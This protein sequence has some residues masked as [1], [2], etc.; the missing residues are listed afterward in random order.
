MKP[1]KFERNWLH[2]GYGTLWIHFFSKKRE[3]YVIS[4][5][6]QSWK[7][8]PAAPCN[9]LARSYHK[10]FWYWLYPSL[11]YP[12]VCLSSVLSFL[13]FKY[14]YILLLN[15][16]HMCVC[17]YVCMCS[18]MSDSSRHP[19]RSQAARLLCPSDFPC[20]GVGNHFLLQGV[21]FNICLL[22]FCF[23]FEVKYIYD[24]IHKH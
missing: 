14:Q 24:E 3:Y 17:M 10:V 6:Q 8:L 9:L 7:N 11:T 13:S 19:A 21:G 20:N 22:F 4:N 15:T 2:S 23:T 12:S 16:F 18:V 1:Y 5:I